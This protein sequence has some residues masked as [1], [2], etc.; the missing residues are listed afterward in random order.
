M[1]KRAICEHGV[2][3]CTNE[4]LAFNKAHLCHSGSNFFPSRYASDRNDDGM[5]RDVREALGG[6]HW[7]A[8][9]RFAQASWMDLYNVDRMFVVG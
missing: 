3:C 1:T 9:D 8:V 5:T 2:L 6:D 7:C 4:I